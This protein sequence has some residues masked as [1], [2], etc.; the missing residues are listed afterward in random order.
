M[1]ELGK[2]IQRKVP[3]KMWGKSL[4]GLGLGTRTR[5]RSSLGIKKGALFGL[6][7]ADKGTETL[8]RKGNKG[9]LWVLE[10]VKRL[11]A[12]RVQGPTRDL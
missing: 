8:A 7:G 9:L 12:A 4:E 2:L 10:N 5:P 1:G 3:T 11:F 6:E